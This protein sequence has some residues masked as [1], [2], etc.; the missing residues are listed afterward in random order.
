MIIMKTEYHQFKAGIYKHYKGHHYLVLGLAHD[1]ND[2][3]RIVVVYIGLELAGAK[4]GPRLSV[5]SYEDFYAWVDQETGRAAPRAAP[6]AIRRF[7]YI[8]QSLNHKQI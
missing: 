8:G 3:A 1:A 5:R 7:T 6:K 4:P 2:E